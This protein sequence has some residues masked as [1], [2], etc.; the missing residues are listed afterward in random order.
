MTINSRTKGATFERA[1]AKEV[2][3]LSSS[4]RA[5]WLLDCFRKALCAALG[6]G[7]RVA[8]QVLRRL[9]AWVT[10]QRLLARP[11]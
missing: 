5:V 10:G 7:R 6:L 1:I 2:L 4:E 3:R 9:P 11:R 8:D